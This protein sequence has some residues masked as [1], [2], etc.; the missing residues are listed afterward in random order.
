M[1][2]RQRLYAFEWT[3]CAIWVFVWGS[4]AYIALTEKSITLG[5]G[6]FGLGGGHY[7]GGAAIFV[8]IV[9]LAAVAGGVG[10]LF[11]LNAFRRLQRFALFVLWLSIAVYYI[12]S[13]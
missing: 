13:I 6:K 4:L 8:G 9:A 10:W 5:A 7:E 3:G 2:S 1:G 11:R 12:V